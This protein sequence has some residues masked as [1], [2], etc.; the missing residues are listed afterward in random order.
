MS[1][2]VELNSKKIQQLRMQQCG[3]Q[4]ELAWAC[5]LSIR[6]IRRVEKTGNASLETAKALASVF[7]ITPDKLQADKDFSHL[8][9]YFICKYAW[10]LAFTLS[11][12]FFGFWIIDIL[13]PTLKGADF[14]Q[15]YE[16]HGNFRYLDYGGISFFLG[17]SLLALNI[18]VDHLQRKKLAVAVAD[19]CE[20]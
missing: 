16:M 9:F 14:N 3:S 17:F 8:T 6:T 5:D 1:T 10:L 18:F 12:L 11:S 4:E 19:K 13:I 15:Q 20:V 7:N 2:Y